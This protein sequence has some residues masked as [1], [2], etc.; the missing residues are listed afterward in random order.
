MVASVERAQQQE[1]DDPI[2][3]QRQLSEKMVFDDDEAGYD[4]SGDDE[5]PTMEENISRQDAAQLY[6]HPEID[7][8]LW[9]E[10]IKIL[11]MKDRLGD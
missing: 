5:I 7:P 2:A 10:L 9:D 3:L 4:F 8:E 11:K 1:P 6:H